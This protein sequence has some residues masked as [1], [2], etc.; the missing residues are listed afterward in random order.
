MVGIISTIFSLNL[1]SF[2]KRNPCENYILILVSLV[3]FTYI[4]I[5]LCLESSNFSYDIFHITTFAFKETMI[6]SF[7]DTNKM[8]AIIVVVFDLA[9]TIFV[10]LIL[11]II[12]GK[13]MK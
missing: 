10:T 7:T 4:S 8:R 1:A 13:L 2:Y 12:F 11:K 6:D 5:L 3:Y 9:S